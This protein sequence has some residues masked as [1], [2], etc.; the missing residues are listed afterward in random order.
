[1]IFFRQ[2]IKRRKKHFS[3]INLHLLFSFTNIIIP[4]QYKKQQ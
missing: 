1:L 4:Y 3:L 2:K